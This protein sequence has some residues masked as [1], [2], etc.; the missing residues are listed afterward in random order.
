MTIKVDFLP[1]EK[2]G[3]SIKYFFG[4]C[5]EFVRELWPFI[6][7]LFGGTFCIVFI[8]I[9]QHNYG[10]RKEVFENSRQSHVIIYSPD[11]QVISEFDAKGF[12]SIENGRVRF[13][14]LQTNKQIDLN[15]K[16]LVVV[17]EL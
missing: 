16:D 3:F 4:N 5:L 9:A 14:D 12:V 1:T 15:T 6:L 17:K 8:L 2:R 13:K 7:I 11:N 10:M